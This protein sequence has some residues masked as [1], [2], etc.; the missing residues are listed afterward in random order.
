MKTEQSLAVL[1]QQWLRAVADA[2][3]GLDPAPVFDRLERKYQ[4][5][6]KDAD[7]ASPEHETGYMA[8]GDPRT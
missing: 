2:S 5:I 6:M 7:P 1:R 3:Y 4:D 8:K